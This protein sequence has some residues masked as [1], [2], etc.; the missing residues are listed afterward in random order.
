MLAGL[1]LHLRKSRQGLFD[2]TEHRFQG[3]LLDSRI[4]AKRRQCLPLT[5]E[6]LHQIGLQICATRDL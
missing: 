4:A 2:F 5:L 1:A 3:V 6:F